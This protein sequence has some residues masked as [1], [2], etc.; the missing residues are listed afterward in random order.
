MA[1]ITS[2]LTVT[3]ATYYSKIFLE[4]ARLLIR[5]DAFAQKRG[6]PANQGKVVNFTRHVQ[7][8]VSTTGLT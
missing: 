8:A 3:M 4:K 7:P 2:G 6:V 1:V 5:H